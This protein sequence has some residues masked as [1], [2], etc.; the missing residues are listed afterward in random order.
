M[1]VRFW[2]PPTKG[3]LSLLEHSHDRTQTTQLTLRSIWEGALPDPVQKVG[4]N[5]PTLHPNQ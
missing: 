3:Y 5:L 2:G 1:V 4:T